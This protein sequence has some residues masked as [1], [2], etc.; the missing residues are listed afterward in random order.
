MK[1]ILTTTM[2]KD[3]SSL[4]V[5]HQRKLQLLCDAFIYTRFACVRLRDADVGKSQSQILIIVWWTATF[6]CVW[7]K[8]SRTIFLLHKLDK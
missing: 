8:T 5:I 4:I 1:Y 3:T 6:D 7:K 2:R